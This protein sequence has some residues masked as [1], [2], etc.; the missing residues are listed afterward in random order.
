MFDS[1]D[2]LDIFHVRQRR[3]TRYGGGGRT[4]AHSGRWLGS[5]LV[6]AVEIDCGVN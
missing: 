5:R 4:K 6:R 2:E 3:R 1:A